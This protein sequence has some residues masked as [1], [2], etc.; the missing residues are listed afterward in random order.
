[1]SNAALEMAPD[2]AVAIDKNVQTAS[3]SL[4]NLRVLN[5]ERFQNSFFFSPTLRRPSMRCKV[6]DVSKLAEYLKVL[7]GEVQAR[8]QEL[9]AEGLSEADARKQIQKESRTAAD[10]DPRQLDAI[11]KGNIVLPKTINTTKA[12]L[13]SEAL[14]ALNEFMNATKARLCGP[15]GVMLPS[16]IQEGLFVC[17]AASVETVEADIKA[18]IARLHNPWTDNKGQEHPG[19]VPAFMADYEAAKAR[20][21]DL[22]LLKGGLGPLFDAADYPA[23]GEISGSFEITRRWLAI[24]VPQGLPEAMRAEITAEF[25]RDCNEAAS[26]MKTAIYEQALGLVNHLRE[27]LTTEPGEKQKSFKASTVENIAAFCDVFEQRN[28]MLSDDGLKAIVNQIKETMI[29]VTPD[30]LRTYA[31]VRENVSAQFAEISK[32]LDGMI[33]VRKGRKMYLDE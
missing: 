25:Q 21:R 1:M 29:G 14:D 20:A 33:E 16:R 17:P 26:Q 6:K 30:K 10:L 2:Q 11:A 8:I 18:A 24:G 13:Q 19:Y 9:S 12:L 32:A 23:P 31:S 4:E 22:P 5:V 28:A 27:V 15:F 3:A 7:A